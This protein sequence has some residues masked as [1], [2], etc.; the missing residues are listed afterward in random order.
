M[1]CT[2]LIAPPEQLDALTH[3][4]SVD[5]ELLT[6]PH[7]EPLL[8]LETIVQR[9][10]SVVGLERL[11]AATPRGAALIN[12]I[13]ADP[14]LSGSEIRVLAHDSDYTRV[15]PR[16]VKAVQPLDQR[17]TRRAARFRMAGGVNALIDGHLAT[18][19]DLS[20][21]GAQVISA[22][23]LKPNQRVRVGLKDDQ[24]V[25]EFN[26]ELVWTSFEIGPAG[27][28]RYRAGV[29]FTDANAT[30]VDAFCARHKAP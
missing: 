15:V 17:G 6:F 1:S 2:V 29:N 25:L 18:L 4:A 10:P 21:V 26:A 5:G 12:R 16:A 28:A 22:A 20:T 24:G 14:A 8:A 19:V 30:G 3:R 13:K 27:G 7:T 23:I 9:R 11:F